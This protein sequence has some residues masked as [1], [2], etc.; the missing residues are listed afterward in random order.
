[1]KK[2]LNAKEKKYLEFDERYDN[3]PDGAYFLAMEQARF[4]AETIIELS[5]S[6]ARKRGETDE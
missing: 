4:D 2:R 3:L 6:I 5:E 1:M